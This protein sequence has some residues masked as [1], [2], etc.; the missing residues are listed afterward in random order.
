MKYLLTLLIL[1]SCASAPKKPERNYDSS[2]IVDAL[3][4]IDSSIEKDENGLVAEVKK[5][6]DGMIWQGQYCGVKGCSL[7]SYEDEDR[8]GKFYRRPEPRCWVK[9]KEG[10]RQGS[11]TNWSRDMA[12]CGLGIYALLQR[13]AE[14][15][16]RHV[17]YGRNNLWVMGEP[18]LAKGNDPRVVYTPNMRAYFYHL[19]AHLGNKKY[20]GYYWPSTY[21]KGQTDYHAHLQLCSIFVRGESDGK[22]NKQMKARVEE[23]YKRDKTDLFAAYLY[24]RYTGNYDR[25]YSACSSPEILVPSYVR[26]DK[27]K[28]DCKAAHKVF[29]CSLLLKDLGE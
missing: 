28:H 9:E 16:S 24:G 26:C 4:V 21:P 11:A 25:I 22:I 27:G 29:V 15:V 20:S 23:H 13:D 18:L 2:K 17:E 5:D 14:L 10:T 12:S 6:C 1:S 7:K 3:E 19:S 8:P